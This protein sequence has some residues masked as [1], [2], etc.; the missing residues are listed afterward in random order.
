M[1]ID[2][3]EQVPAPAAR[4]VL[5]AARNIVDGGSLTVIAT[6][7]RAVRRRD[8]G[9]RPGRRAARQHLGASRRWT[10]VASATVRAELLVGEK[11]AEAIAEARS[12]R[13]RWGEG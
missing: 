5:P 7:P 4:R 10:S 11:G 3:L 6:A 13:R 12:W 2:S 1:L 9:H 8:R